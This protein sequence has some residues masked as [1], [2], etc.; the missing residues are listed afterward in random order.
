MAIRSIDKSLPELQLEYALSYEIMLLSNH[1]QAV[2]TC[3]VAFR[4]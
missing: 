3:N 2:D 4:I 1:I